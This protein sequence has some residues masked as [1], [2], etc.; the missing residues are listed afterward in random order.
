MDLDARGM[1]FIK[2]FMVCRLPATGNKTSQVNGCSEIMFPI[3]SG[4]F[5]NNC[6]GVGLRCL[7]VG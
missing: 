5:Q 7:S 4:K 1:P 3:T 2:T 6:F